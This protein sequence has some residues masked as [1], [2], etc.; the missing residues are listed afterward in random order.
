[1]NVK[2]LAEKNYPKYWSK[3]RLAYLVNIGRLT[4]EDYAE[5]TERSNDEKEITV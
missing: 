4:K 3:E 2:E 1:M 5:I